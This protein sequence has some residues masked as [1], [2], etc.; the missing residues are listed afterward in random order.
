MKRKG[1]SSHFV[2][3]ANHGIAIFFNHTK[4]VFNNTSTA[5]HIVHRNQQRS[6]IILY[7]IEWTLTDAHS[8]DR[9]EEVS[10]QE[11]QYAPVLVEGRSGIELEELN[12][13][14][15]GQL[16]ALRNRDTNT[17]NASSSTTTSTSSRQ[18]ILLTNTHLFWNWKYEFVKLKQM[19]LLLNEVGKVSQY[20]KSHSCS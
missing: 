20:C 7:C 15:F 18:G 2:A 6:I 13:R 11:I 8:N 16:L 17:E 12:R 14:N 10:Y 1:F 3:G 19:E 5:V 9:F 4:L